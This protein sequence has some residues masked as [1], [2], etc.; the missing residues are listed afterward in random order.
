M[1]VWPLFRPPFEY[2]T[3]YCLLF[4]P[5]FEY[6]TIRWSD[7][8]EPFEYRTSPL[9]RSPLYLLEICCING[10]CSFCFSR[11]SCRVGFFG[12][13]KGRTRRFLR[14]HR[15][16]V[17]DSSKHDHS[18][19]APHFA[20]AQAPALTRP[21]LFEIGK[22]SDSLFPGDIFLITFYGL[23]FSQQLHTWNILYFEDLCTSDIVRFS[24]PMS[25]TLTSRLRPRI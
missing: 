15:R 12:R 23:Y 7:Y 14:R 3:T 1:V 11:W 21:R 19:R 20:I 8:F 22:S 4:R 25:E 10:F 17:S 16:D 5:P 2:R 9:F 18:K 13:R 24:W 6:R